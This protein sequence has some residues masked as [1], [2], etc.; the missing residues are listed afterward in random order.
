MESIFKRSL[1]K[2]FLP[3]LCL[4]LAF[5]IA[6]LFTDLLTPTYAQDIG[7]SNV[8]YLPAI[9]IGQDYQTTISLTNTESKATEVILTAYDMKGNSL[10]VV[11]SVIRLEAGEAKT[12]DAQT[13]PSGTES[14]KIESDGNIEA[15]VIFKTADGKRSEVIPAIKELSKQLDFPTLV[16]GDAVHKDIILLNPNSN[17]ASLDI[18]VIDINGLE[19]GHKILPSLSP[20]ETII[21]SLADIFDSS[22]LEKLSNIRIISDSNITGLQ[23]VDNP[24]SDLVGLPALT[25]KSK[26]WRFPIKTKDEDLTLWTSVGIFNPTDEIADINIEA[27]D[28]DNH[29][30]GIIE[31]QSISLGATH[32]VITAN[33]KGLIPMNAAYLEVTSNRPVSGYEVMGGIDGYSLSAA[34]GIPD[35]DK[36]LIESKSIL[37]VNA[38]QITSSSFYLQFPLANYTA[39]NAPISSVFDHSMTTSYAKDGIVVAYTGEKGVKSSGYACDCYKNSSGQPFNVDNR[40]KGAGS[41]GGT[42][43]LCYDGHPAYDYPVSSGTEVR[44][45]AGGVVIT[46]TWDNCLG[47]YVKIDHQNGYH[48]LYAHLSSLSVGAN[49]NIG[50]GYP[51]GKSGKTG[52]CSSGAHLHF[53]V[54]KN[55]S[56]VYVPVDP[57]GWKGGTTDPYTKAVN[58]NLWV[59]STTPTLR[60]DGGTSSTKSQGNTFYLTGSYY[61]PNGAVTRYL[62]NP[63]GTTTTLSTIY[64]NSSGN[65]SWSFPSSCSDKTGTYYIRAK[66]N[67]TGKYSNT[68]SEIITFNYSCDK[69]IPN[70]TALSVSPTS[71]PVGKSFTISYSVKDSGGSGLKQ[72]ELWRQPS[73]GSWS[74]IKTTTLSGQ[75]SYSG[76]F[77]NAP[78]SAGTY[79]YGLHV[80]DRAGNWNDEKN[81]RTGYS[82]GQYGP[83]KVVVYNLPT[84]RIDGGTS[85]TRSQGSTFYLTG[86]YY[87]PNGAVT[88]Y[89]KQP[90][91]TTITLSPTLYANSSGN[92][93]WSFTPSCSTRPGTYYLWVK[94]NATGRTSNTVTEIVTRNSSCYP[95]LYINGGTSSTKSQGGTFTCT[96]WNYT[97]NG[98]VTRYLK[99]PNGTTITLTPT[100]YA[101]S[102]SYIS[103]SFTSSCSNAPGTY[104]L[105]VKDNGTGR[106]SNTV[107]EIITHSSSCP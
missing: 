77:S 73:G 84:L 1:L 95:T 26:S 9:D 35:E 44:A 11:T 60:I 64:A 19:I 88:R 106:Y 81:S 39:Y 86:S 76:T 3:L 49:Q 14:L 24:D 23:L 101:N 104:Y 13:L 71:N 4:F 69:T 30:L 16:T 98:A 54:R 22:T 15:S 56:G 5:T 20:M 55:V 102:S 68:V 70:V 107:T 61:T 67:A 105:W 8:L 17:I 27:F 29:S 72:V 90:D 52:S 58:S 32:F 46:A 82:P 10:G 2:V 99:Q 47:N 59:V 65:I 45:A 89:L 37:R 80:V 43:Y 79:W 91:G 18:V 85:S 12:I 94:D 48:T 66:N 96:G 25:I 74:Q 53:E 97:P 100:L 83:D 103:W 57:Y 62:K 75:T 63:A 40:Y 50:M 28:A 31:E 78:S 51:I 34:L 21:I 36:S 93:S 92:I 7:H 41:C 33:I 42:F 38:L 87:T 6:P